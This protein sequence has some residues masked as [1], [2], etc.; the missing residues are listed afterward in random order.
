MA[1]KNKPPYGETA[2]GSD[3]TIHA[4]Q[5]WIMF[6][7]LGSA[8]ATIDCLDS[9]SNVVFTATL[10]AGLTINLGNRI[11]GNDWAEFTIKPGSSTVQAMFESP[12]TPK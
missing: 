5:T 12:N 7:N 8:D 11:D 6:T 3:V 2:N 4:G 1:I 9:N 10:L